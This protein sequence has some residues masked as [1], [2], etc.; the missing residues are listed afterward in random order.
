MNARNQSKNYSLAVTIGTLLCLFGTSVMVARLLFPGLLA[1]LPGIEALSSVTTLYQKY[2]ITG[3]E[4]SVVDYLLKPYTLERF[5]QSIDKII[6]LIA[7]QNNEY[8][9]IKSENR[10]EKIVLDEI[11]FIE[12]M[13]DYLRIHTTTKKIMTL[14]SFNGILKHL[15]SSH[16]IRVHNSYIVAINKIE[17]IERNRI[18]IREVYIPISDKYKDDFFNTIKT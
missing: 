18:K 1:H 14:Q 17:S 11:L 9:F 3:Y 6:G 15:P 12:G 4:F 5:L 16:F 7:S 10:I 2:A 8:I 13:K